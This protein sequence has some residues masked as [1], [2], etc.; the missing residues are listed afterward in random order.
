M[1]NPFTSFHGKWII[2]RVQYTAKLLIK[3]VES[4][5]QIR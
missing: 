4:A 1:M 3:S 2:A 5:E